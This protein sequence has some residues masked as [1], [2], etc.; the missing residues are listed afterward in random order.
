MC[1]I[2]TLRD[3]SF[4]LYNSEFEY[5]FVDDYLKRMVRFC[6]VL[7]D[8]RWSHYGMP[9]LVSLHKRAL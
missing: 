9:E 2:T 6:G 5:S 1:D 3:S 4:R 8:M 7:F